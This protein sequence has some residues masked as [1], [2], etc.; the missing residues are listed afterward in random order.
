LTNI[1]HHGRLWILATVT[2]QQSET[3]KETTE[4][5]FEDKI[6]K[7][8]RENALKLNEI[9]E[10][11]QSTK[12]A[13]DSQ[14]AV[15]SA[16]LANTVAKSEQET[17]HF[18]TEQTNVKNHFDIQLATLGDQLKSLNQTI[19]IKSEKIGTLEAEK[20]QLEDNLR[21]AVKSCHKTTEQ[22]QLIH[23]QS[24]SLKILA[25]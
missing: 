8:K 20:A 25:T 19:L 1:C 13:M 12:L 14:F 5:D 10:M 7:I 4:M 6:N 21:K 3:S 24:K 15:T 9:N 2:K 18:L 17:E 22:L 16:E 23:A 11:M